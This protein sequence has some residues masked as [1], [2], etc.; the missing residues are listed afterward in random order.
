MLQFKESD[1]EQI[2][3]YKDWTEDMKVS[4]NAICGETAKKIGYDI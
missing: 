3:N 1:I 4:F 2:G